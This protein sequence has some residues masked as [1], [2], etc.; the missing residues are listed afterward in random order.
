MVL[1]NAV[2]FLGTWEKPF[3]SDNTKALPFYVGSGKQPPPLSV[4]CY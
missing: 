1:V 4:S 3:K 2:Y